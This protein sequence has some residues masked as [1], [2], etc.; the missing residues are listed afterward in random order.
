MDQINVSV[1]VSV[2]RA[3]MPDTPQV[4]DS[5]VIRSYTT[6]QK[7]TKFETQVVTL[8][9]GSN[10]A[11][12]RTHEWKRSHFH[13]RTI[14]YLYDTRAKQMVAVLVGKMFDASVITDVGYDVFLIEYL[15]SH[16]LYFG[17]H[18]TSRLFEHIRAICTKT[19]CHI[20]TSAKPYNIRWFTLKSFIPIARDEYVSIVNHA[21]D[22]AIVMSYID[23]KLEARFARLCKLQQARLTRLAKVSITP[24]TKPS[25]L[26][27]KRQGTLDA[28]CKA[29]KRRKL[30]T[31]TLYV[32]ALA[33]DIVG[34]TC[35][36]GHVLFR[37]VRLGKT[38]SVKR[39]S[40]VV[41][42]PIV[43]DVAEMPEAHD[44]DVLT[45]MSYTHDHTERRE[46]SPFGYL[47]DGLSMHT[48]NNVASSPFPD[49]YF[50]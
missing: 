27:R 43:A 29:S 11:I 20:L 41:S 33:D 6:D 34:L 8:L 25:T 42:A 18:Y 17:K 22:D 48:S 4:N 35:P 13:E 30:N 44:I 19:K 46:P 16:H 9:N 32:R 50:F 45:S 28:H 7:N 10:A 3:R 36:P 2:N 37:P 39:S 12:K 47:F 15:C 49:D 14:Y 23:K 24:I 1:S 5:L 26:K 40:H 31:E 21:D 38:G